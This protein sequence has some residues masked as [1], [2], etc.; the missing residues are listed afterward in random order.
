[1]SDLIKRLNKRADEFVIGAA[2]HSCESFEY[3]WLI[4][5]TDGQV[6]QASDMITP[7][8]LREAARRIEELEAIV[9][10]PRPPAPV[11]VANPIERYVVT[12]IAGNSSRDT[13]A[14]ATGLSTG[15]IEQIEQ[16][17][18]RAILRRINEM[19]LVLQQSYDYMQD[20]PHLLLTHR[21]QKL[22]NGEA[23][24]NVDRF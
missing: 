21:I 1:M 12:E 9:R 3:A 17:A 10:R 5:R 22:L 6:H 24:S 20:M 14:A 19:E 16:N 13:I 8:L 18:V 2:G 23:L 15:R 4:R 7:D 11:V